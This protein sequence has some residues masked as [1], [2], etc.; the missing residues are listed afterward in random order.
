M[1]KTTRASSSPNPNSTTGQIADTL[2]EDILLG[3]IKSRQP[4]R[5]DE[6]ASQFGVS[7]IP[8]REALVQLKA[9]G[10]VKFIPN[11][12]A[13]VSD[14]SAAEADEIYV[15]RIALETSILARAIPHLTVADLR[16]AEEILAAIDQE[17]NVA[18]WGELNWAFHANLYAPAGMPRLIETIRTL[19]VNVARYLVLYLSGLEYQ[20][21]S[22]QEHRSLLEACRYG[23]IEEASLILEKHLRSAA[24]QLIAFLQEQEKPENKKKEGIKP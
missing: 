23:N 4:L 20:N 6:I 21:L 10:L 11:R 2:R 1:I 24:R 7:K 14:L 3:K 13:F 22:Q 5:Q 19:H 18:R 15:M 9:E 12:G 16:Q 17:E 8:I